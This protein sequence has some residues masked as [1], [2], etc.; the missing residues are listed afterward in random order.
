MFL[1]CHYSYLK[2]F[3]YLA[4]RPQM[5]VHPTVLLPNCR[6]RSAG[7]LHSMPLLSSER[8]CSRPNRPPSSNERARHPS[9][10]INTNA[11]AE[12]WV[13]S[14]MFQP[15]IPHCTNA[16]H[17][18][19]P[20]P[21][22]SSTA[23][24]L[25]G[26]LQPQTHPT[27]QPS[28]LRTRSSVLPHGIPLSYSGRSCS[29]PNQPS[30]SCESGGYPLSPPDANAQAEL[31][32]L[33]HRHDDNQLNLLV[34]QLPHLH[35]MA[36]LDHRSIQSR[37]KRPEDHLRHV[38][39]S[40]ASRGPSLADI[41]E[42]TI[43]HLKQ[44]ERD[45]VIAL[46][47]L[48][49]NSGH[50]RFRAASRLYRNTNTLD[51]EN[52]DTLQILQT[53]EEEKEAGFTDNGQNPRARIVETFQYSMDLKAPLFGCACCGIRTFQ[54]AG[55]DF[56]VP[57]RI[58]LPPL[59]LAE[60]YVIS[61]A[62]LYASVIKLTGAT[63]AQRHTARQGHVIAFPQPES[64]ELIAEQARA[65]GDTGERTYPRADGLP[66]FISIA[67]IALKHLNH[68]YANITIDDTPEMEASLEHIVDDLIKHARVVSD[69]VGIAVNRLATDEQEQPI[70]PMHGQ[71]PEEDM[72]LPQGAQLPAVFLGKSAH[73]TSDRYGPAVQASAESHEPARIDIPDVQS[74]LPICEFEGNDR[75]LYSAFPF[76]FLLGSGLRKPGSVAHRD[77]RHMLL[78]FTC[79]FAT[80]HRFL[81]C[82]FDQLQR[83][84]AARA[85]SAR[86]KNNP[87]SL[88]KLQAWVADPAFLQDLARAARNPQHKS[89]R[90]LVA[91][92]TPHIKTTSSTVPYSSAQR[93]ASM[94]HLYALA[95][96]FGMPSLFLTYT[97]DFASGVLNLRLSLP[98]LNN[99]ELS[100]SDDGILEALRQ[101]RDVHQ[102]IRLSQ[103]CLNERLA[104]NPVAMAEFF[105]LLTNSIFTILVGLKPEGLAR[106]T[107]ELPSRKPG[108]FGLP[109]ASFGVVEEQARGTPHC[110]AIVWGGLPPSLLQSAAGAPR[111][112][113]V[114]A[115]LLDRM[116]AAELEPKTIAHHLLSQFTGTRLVRVAAYIAHCP[117]KEPREFAEDVQRAASFANLHSHSATCHK[118][119]RGKI[120]CR[121]GR[122]GPDAEKSHVVQLLPYRDPQTG[123][124]LYDILY[125]PKPPCIDSLPC[126]NFARTPVAQRNTNLHF[127]ELKRRIRAVDD[128]SLKQMLNPDLLEQVSALTD[129]QRDR[130]LNTL[131]YRN[132]MVV[133]FN[134]VMTA[135]LGCNSNVSILGS[136]AQAKAIMCYL[137][138]YI[139][140]PPC[141]LSHTLALIHNARRTVEHFPSTAKDTGTERRTAMHF[142][143]RVV[144]QLTSAVEVSAPVASL[145]LLGVPSEICSH[146]FHLLFVHAA[147][148]Y[149]LKKGCPQ[150]SPLAFDDLQGNG[151][152]SD[153]EPLTPPATNSVEQDEDPEELLE[154]DQVS[155]PP[156]IV[157]TSRNAEPAEDDDAHVTATVYSSGKEK[158]A[159]TLTAGKRSYT[160]RLTSTPPRS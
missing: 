101:Q 93:K 56:G 20:P 131:A 69:D 151:L 48:A 111:L 8:P 2:F 90:A 143:T 59:R 153:D 76:L 123:K 136:D 148:A 146:G 135:L 79:N 116:V 67:F 1:Q 19:P 129:E 24:T 73:P 61:R 63:S 145:A 104:S 75:L 155:K 133:E 47:T 50:N 68:F 126:R 16:A 10:P 138:K 115:S 23:H 21:L 4:G 106:Y 117:V 6:G 52:P 125:E 144:N 152:F 46:I 54:M 81:F 62:R 7:P 149:V 71:E 160:T 88:E 39:R 5:Q 127:W 55:I 89:A 103:A 42:P 37:L 77:C 83:H 128:E 78:Q 156:Y 92:V 36:C 119:T 25:Q 29:R 122:P 130:F 26:L 17:V 11:Q 58:R 109:L 51:L 121:L 57:S 147:L 97:P 140:K 113:D 31:L 139:I 87:E 30:A 35:K 22:S 120:C 150:E 80:C 102:K 3:I 45:P 91:R 44:F 134:P 33:D 49:I 96:H 110:H 141:E 124:V 86:F 70:A 95:Q 65:T 142:L 34:N 18:R 107:P 13:H 137:L 154:D 159:V 14:P 98:L 28:N 41:H 112:L 12:A 15:Q 66:A 132:G 72:E 84:A 32:H 38:H 27:R 99:I 43:Q 105:R 40:L 64:A 82:L 114:I 53:I 100:A 118:G 157:E 9:S 60:Q 158:K 85:V 108:L 94:Q 74:H